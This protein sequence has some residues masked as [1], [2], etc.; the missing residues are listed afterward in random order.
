MF[1][2][3]HANI[4]LEN[5]FINKIETL[6]FKA[7]KHPILKKIQPVELKIIVTRS[8]HKKEGAKII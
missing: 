8:H 2:I 3:H 4:S 6:D 7:I 5:A 1:V